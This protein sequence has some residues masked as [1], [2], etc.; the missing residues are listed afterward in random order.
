MPESQAPIGFLS[1]IEI[2]KKQRED[3]KTGTDELKK[4]LTLSQKS[5]GETLAKV[6][7]A[8]SEVNQQLNRRIAEKDRE[9]FTKKLAVLNDRKQNILAIQEAGKTL[10]E[11]KD[12]HDR[13]LLEMIEF[14]Q[15]PKESLK[16]AYS[17][18]DFREAQERTGNEAT[19]VENLKKKRENI[20][21]QNSAMVDRLASWEKQ[22][23][24]KKRAED[25][26]SI[27][28]SREEKTTATLALQAEILAL[29]RETVTEKITYAKLSL[30][31]LSYEERILDD[32]ID[33]AVQKLARQKN[34]LAYI[35]KRLVFTQ[36]DILFAKQELNS[37]EQKTIIQKEKIN[38]I[39]L[40]K[41]Q[42][43]NNLD[44]SVIPLQEK[45]QAIEKEGKENSVSYYVI[46]SQEKKILA[47]GNNIAREIDV[48]ETQKELADLRVSE[49]EL[50]YSTIKARYQLRSS[51]ENLLEILEIFKNKRN[52]A[53]DLGK[54]LE[55]K[56]DIANTAQIEANQNLDIITQ[57]HDDVTTKKAAL[58]VGHEEEYDA[59]VKN[60]ARAKQYTNQQLALILD[61]LTENTNL[62]SQQSKIIMQLDLTVE[63]LK[64][65]QKSQNIWK[66]SPHAIS[67][68]ALRRS[69]IEAEM[70][71]KSVYWS[72][73]AYL[74]PSSLIKSFREFTWPEIW[75]LFLC[76]IFYFILF[77]L[78]RRFVLYLRNREFA[79]TKHF[80]GTKQL[81]KLLLGSLI[82]FI[83]D[84]F[85]LLFTWLFLFLHVFF[86]FRFIFATLEPLA[87]PYII[88]MFYFVSIPILVYFSHQL[89]DRLKELNTQ[90]S[91]LLFAESL[92]QKFIFLITIFCYATAILL[93]IRQAFVIYV[94]DQ[95]S[96]FAAVLLAAYSLIMILLILFSFGKDDILKLIPTTNNFF[97]LLKRKIDQHYYP[98]FLSFMGLLIL[99]NP[100]I[101]YM[102]MAWFLAFAVPLTGL[103]MYATFM[104]HYYLRTYAVFM[105]MKEEEDEFVDKFEHAKA[106]YGFFII[107]SFLAICLSA[108]FIACRIWGF[109]YTPQDIWETLSRRWVIPIGVD[110]YFGIIEVVIMTLFIVGG[111]LIS[112]LINKFVLNKLFDI[113]R[114][115][116]GTQNTISRIVHYLIIFVA[117]IM[118]MNVIH[119]GQF[120]FWISALAVGLGFGLK[121]VAADLIGG[122]LILI[123]RP[124]EIGNFI[125]IDQQQGTVH[126]IAA[127]YTTLI[128]ATNHTVVIPNKDLASKWIE[129]WGH[130]RFAI[131]FEMAVRVEHNTDPEKVRQV[132]FNVIQGHPLILKVPN[133]V[134]RLEGFEENSL[135]FLVRAFISA[136]RVKEQW[137]IASDLRITI[138]KTFGEHGIILAKPVRVI[139]AA[140][141]STKVGP[142]AIEIKFGSG[143][144]GQ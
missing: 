58:F 111:F 99:S 125:Q 110:Q 127:R 86:D 43:K 123:E 44:E 120:V 130:G 93:P 61:Y 51:S 142:G 17:W 14:F 55:D 98:V 115:E 15:E 20:R 49:K 106:Y 25:K 63:D 114:S 13:L 112:S 34:T 36:K 133:A 2:R 87:S 88:A 16:S 126:K 96:E 103:L 65:K 136:R 3:I 95:K 121:D 31:K 80:G 143:R 135:Y 131:G 82:H 71:L 113:L 94:E 141:G 53:I 83:H 68:S 107:F 39:I 10:M 24:V 70:L 66:R 104:A 116:P 97:I 47:Q 12:R 119:L 28:A 41:Q 132:L 35:E 140:D 59:V 101:G 77:F 90:M 129:N 91:F 32:M 9:V 23:E 85:K 108:F 37:E 5:I 137:T 19:N 92:Q 38:E 73:P 102:N 89:I 128:T 1:E 33:F 109:E 18:K 74:S 54:E 69:F 67:T 64:M 6:S 76:V 29:E 139:Q 124:I 62:I 81:S 42:A 75:G 56:R 27:K 144:D 72:T 118:G 7:S 138:L 48:L 26:L 84:H 4:R 117:I 122:F 8:S 40:V 21:K 50:Q 52:Q 45:L 78:C 57:M 60:I 79:N 22:L 46:K 30:E 100:Y 105:F 134:V 11:Q